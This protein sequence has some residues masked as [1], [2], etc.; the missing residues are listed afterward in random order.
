MCCISDMRCSSGITKRISL[1][2]AQN[3][4]ARKFVSVDPLVRHCLGKL[5]RT[6]SIVARS[7]SA[8]STASICLLRMENRK[9]SHFPHSPRIMCCN[10]VIELGIPHRPRKEG[11]VAGVERQ[12]TA[13]STSWASFLQVLL[14]EWTSTFQPPSK[15]APSGCRCSARC[16]F[17]K[18]QR[19]YPFIT[20]TSFVNET[21]Q[22]H[23]YHTGSG[24]MRWSV[25]DTRTR[26][27]MNCMVLSIMS[28][29]MRIE[30]DQIPS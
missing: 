29:S 21:R 28:L 30:E 14:G 1:E 12:F 20:L 25:W 13:S 11:R 26:Q 23:L 15:L 8:G 17:V 2:W 27:R 3:Q 5:I 10:C 22:F 6:Q 19:I 9:V 18:F 7:M 4:E 16:C 24:D